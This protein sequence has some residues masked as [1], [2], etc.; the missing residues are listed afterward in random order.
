[1]KKEITCSHLS[2]VRSRDPPKSP[3]GS[4][5]AAQSLGHQLCL[6][7]LLGDPDN[8]FE[9]YIAQRQISV[10]CLMRLVRNFCSWQGCSSAVDIPVQGAHSSVKCDC[11]VPK[12]CSWESL[13]YTAF[14]WVN[15]CF[16]APPSHLGRRFS[17]SLFINFCFF[18]NLFLCV[19]I[20]A[21]TAAFSWSAREWPE[22]QTSSGAGDVWFPLL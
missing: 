11:G 10:F 1:M 4:S 12:D 21:V 20:D 19:F 16:F 6:E 13:Y 2:L 18:F 3:T 17:P 9:Q 14:P 15:T 5:K 7:H 22:Q 8:P